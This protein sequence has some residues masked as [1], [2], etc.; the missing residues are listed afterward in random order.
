MFVDRL[1]SQ[2]ADGNIPSIVGMFQCCI[3]LSS[4]R[5]HCQNTFNSDLIY[6]I[7][8][9]TYLLYVCQLEKYCTSHSSSRICEFV[10]TL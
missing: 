2:T 4:A 3:L 8:I 9:L 5:R 7:I 6:D 1:M 10:S